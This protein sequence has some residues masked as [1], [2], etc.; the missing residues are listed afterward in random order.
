MS[1]LIADSRTMVEKARVEAQVGG[2]W[3]RGG[4]LV[5]MHQPLMN[6]VATQNYWFTYNEP[7]SVESV[8]QS[9]S[10][11]ALR[12]SEDDK[13]EEDGMVRGSSW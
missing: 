8:T 5:Q 3:W 2:M 12:F 1:G 13:E 4:G 10:N 6:C 9:V 7:M 11:L